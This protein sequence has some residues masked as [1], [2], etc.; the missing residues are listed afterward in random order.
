[1]DRLG[2]GV[3]RY[4]GEEFVTFTEQEGLVNNSVL[5]II[6]DRNGHLWFGTW[7]GISRYDGRNFENYAVKDGVINNSIMSIKEDLEGNIWFGTWGGGVSRYDG[8]Q[9]RNFTTEDGMLSNWVTTIE[10]DAEGQ[11]YFG[12]F[13]GVSR[14][15]GTVFQSLTRQN[16]LVHNAVQGLLQ[17]RSGNIWIATEGGVT[18]Y[19]PLRIAP[20]VHIANVTA[21]KNYGSVNE[22]DLPT[23]Q[24]YLLV[25]FQGV[26]LQTSLKN[27]VYVYRLQ[28]YD[29]EWRETATNRI[30]YIN[31]PLGNYVFQVQ[32][33]DRDINYSIE[34]AEIRITIHPPYR[35]IALA[36]GLGFALIGLIAVTR[37]AVR[38]RR[39]LRRAERALMQELEE[40][41]Q[42]AHKMQMGLMPEKSPQISGF[43]ITGRCL[44]ANHVGGDFFQYLNMSQERY[45]IALADVT[46]H[47]MEAAIPALLFD[48]ILESQIG[49]DEEIDKLFRNLNRILHKKLNNRTFV[50]FVMGKLDPSKGIIEITNGGC[51]Y[52]FHFRH[53]TGDIIELQIDAY[54]LGVRPDYSYSVL[55]IQLEPGDR[56][57]FCSDGIIEATNASG[58]MFGFERTANVVLE[59]SKEGLSAEDLLEYIFS[60]INLFT[61]SAPRTDDQTIVVLK[62]ERQDQSS[63]LQAI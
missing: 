23:T 28:G 59:G 31:L 26:S 12:T 49:L 19:R 21:D 29:R 39:D 8:I 46:G 33:I 58:D 27:I 11:L 20:T 30:E 5:S 41:L 35:S 47:A 36:G 38:K 16:G 63:A 15:D 1:M 60:E 24:D 25:E 48:G 7:S 32:A 57:V 13:G 9:F 22:I 62:M 54:P 4:D 3:S 37:Y 17:D 18:R 6:E 52:P 51:P 43:D 14:F 53:S 40:E 55:E 42:V 10:T 45:A 2:S 56:V 34:P 50:C 61:K 44:T